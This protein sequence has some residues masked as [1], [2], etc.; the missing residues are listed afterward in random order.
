MLLNSSS[1]RPGLLAVM[2]F[3]CGFLF[4]GVRRPMAKL[5]A[6]L[7]APASPLFLPAVAVLMGEMT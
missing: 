5:A 7:V 4:V 3:L 6:T 2:A 1:V